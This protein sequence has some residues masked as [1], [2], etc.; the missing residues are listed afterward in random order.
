MRRG[1]YEQA[2]RDARSALSYV[3]SSSEWELFDADAAVPLRSL[4]ELDNH[5]QIAIT[6]TARRAA[7]ARAMHAAALE[8]AGAVANAGE[9]D[10]YH[11][12]FNPCALDGD[13]DADD[14]TVNARTDKS[15]DDVTKSSW[16]NSTTTMGEGSVDVNARRSN[17]DRTGPK[18]THLTT[19]GVGR[20]VLSRAGEGGRTEDL[21]VDSG[22][23]AAVEWRRACAL[24]PNRRD[25]SARCRAAAQRYLPTKPRGV[26]IDEGAGATVEWLG[27]FLLIFVWAIGM[28]SC[29][30]HRN[31]KVGQ[32]PRVRAP[33]VQVL[34]LLRVDARAHF[35]PLPALTG[36]HHG[37]AAR[38]GRGRAGPVTPVPEGYPGPGECFFSSLTVC[39]YELCVFSG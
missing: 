21:V 22:V 37:Q 17:A 4:H 6:E 26:L 16:K 19:R 5:V 2:L 30:I 15:Y 24:D 12:E 27:K 34:L 33:A 1:R 10:V 18:R 14:P 25:Y 11:P 31:G 7:A 13:V 28:T 29:F 32:R 38:H 9:L 39:L 36:A 3:P 35:R 8:A 20:V 23:A